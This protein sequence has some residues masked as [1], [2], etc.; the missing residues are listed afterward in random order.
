MGEVEVIVEG[1]AE[2]VDFFYLIKKMEVLSFMDGGKEG[3]YSYHSRTY[4]GCK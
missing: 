4:R 3:N 2:D 1:G